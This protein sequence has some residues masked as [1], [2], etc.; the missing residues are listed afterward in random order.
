MGKQRRAPPV[1]EEVN[2]GNV[3]RNGTAEREELPWDRWPQEAP[4]EG[5]DEAPDD[6]RAPEAAAKL[7]HEAPR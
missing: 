3:G 4:E 6:Y 7:R 1:P 2:D 5:D